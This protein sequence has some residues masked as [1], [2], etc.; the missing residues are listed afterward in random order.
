MKACYLCQ[1]RSIWALVVA[2]LVAVTGMHPETWDRSRNEENQKVSPAPALPVLA[3]RRETHRVPEL[4]A[5]VATVPV[6]ASLDAP[7]ISALVLLRTARVVPH[8]APLSSCSA[9][10]PPL[11]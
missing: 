1:M 3:G 8:A 11:G 4:T 2:C 7:C 9:R 5:P 10:G 6:V